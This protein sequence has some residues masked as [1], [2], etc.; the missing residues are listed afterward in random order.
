MKFKKGQ[1]PWNFGLTKNINPNL[2]KTT[3]YSN[4]I[5][6]IRNCPQC[7][8]P[9]HYSTKYSAI[10]AEQKNRKCK[11]CA[12]KGKENHFHGVIYKRTPEMNMSSRLR[13]IERIKKLKGQKSPNYNPTSIQNLELKAKELKIK[14]LQHAENGGE[15]FIEKLGY[16]VDGYSKEKNI[17][18]EY[19][20]K[21]HFDKNGE[22]IKKDLIRQ[23]QIEDFLNCKFIRIKQS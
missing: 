1:K 14:D 7:N 11:S 3:K 5:D 22:Y 17:V 18:L 16:W 2:C 4:I 9:L 10:Y 13:A 6:F 15:Y 23:K 8:N 12:S 21:H 20:E 19:D